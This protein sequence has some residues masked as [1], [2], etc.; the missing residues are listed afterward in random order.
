MLFTISGL[1]ANASR[2]R[3]KHSASGAPEFAMGNPSPTSIPSSICL[4]MCVPSNGQNPSMLICFPFR[5][6]F[7]KWITCTPQLHDS[8]DWIEER[9]T[10]RGPGSFHLTIY[11][12]EQMR[13]TVQKLKSG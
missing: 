11:K 4:S 2:A 7:D 6:E 3:P 9:L 1:P 8:N 13:Y 10:S 12:S 5:R